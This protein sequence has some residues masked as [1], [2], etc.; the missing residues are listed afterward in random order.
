VCIPTYNEPMPY[1]LESEMS[2]CPSVTQH[3]PTR[4]QGKP[5]LPLPADWPVVVADCGNASPRNMRLTLNSIPSSSDLLK[6]SKMPMAV[7]V[8]P[9][10]PTHPGEDPLQAPPTPLHTPDEVESG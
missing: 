5:M 9:L 1:N 3:F 8:Q 4:E 6:Q 2:D 7:L 10:A